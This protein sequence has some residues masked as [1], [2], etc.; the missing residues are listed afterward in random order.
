MLISKSLILQP[1]TKYIETTT[2]CK[3]FPHLTFDQCWWVCKLHQESIAGKLLTHN[4]DIGEGRRVLMELSLTF[5][6]QY[7]NKLCFIESTQ[8][9]YDW[10][11]APEKI[12][13]KGKPE[14]LSY[15][16]KNM[17]CMV[18]FYQHKCGILVFQS[19]QNNQNVPL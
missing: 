11:S 3:G 9:C 12:Y 15:L 13:W 2:F 5:L 18:R 19:T 10:F 7:P 14:A 6:K 17:A 8:N 16:P 4:I 1:V